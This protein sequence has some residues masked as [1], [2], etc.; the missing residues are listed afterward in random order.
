V[1]EGNENLVYLSPW[2]L[3]RSFTLRKILRHGTSGFTSLP[4]EGVLR[5]FI[6]LKNPLPWPGS[7]QQPLGPVASTLT[8]TPPRRH[9]RRTVTVTVYA[10]VSDKVSHTLRPLLICCASPLESKSFLI[11]LPQLSGDYQHR[12]LV[13]K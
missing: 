1:G 3:K 12:H 5:I 8:S 9:P 4:N 11:H 13:V 6:A 7:N 2:D 10:V